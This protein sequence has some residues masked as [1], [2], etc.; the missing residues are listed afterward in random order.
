M[1][2]SVLEKMRQDVDLNIV[3]GSTEAELIAGINW[4][5]V[6]PEDRQKIAG[7]AGLLVGEVVPEVTCRSEEN[8][9]G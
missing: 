4:A 5:Q 8:P 6:S 2:P 1:Y 9:H 7:G 3:Y